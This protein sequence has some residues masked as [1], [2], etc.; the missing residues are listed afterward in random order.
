MSSRPAEPLKYSNTSA[1]ALSIR[2]FFLNYRG[3]FTNV[4]GIPAWR[5][6]FLFFD[7]NS[8]KKNGFLSSSVSQWHKSHLFLI[9]PRVWFA[10]KLCFHIVFSSEVLSSDVPTLCVFSS[11]DGVRIFIVYFHT[12]FCTSSNTVII[13]KVSDSDSDYI[14]DVPD[15]CKFI[16]FSE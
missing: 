1:F 9:C 15:M 6:R 3:K 11:T 7:F 12:K 4:H 5:N 10:I 2:I 14:C 8:S 16:W 13:R